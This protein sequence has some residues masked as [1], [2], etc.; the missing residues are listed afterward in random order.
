MNPLY[1]M[2]GNDNIVARFQKFKQSFTGDPQKQVQEL[3][4]SGKVSQ[5]DYNKAVQQA[6]SLRKML[7]M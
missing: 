1:Q 7:G 3:L 5:D 2:M 6:Q 4:N